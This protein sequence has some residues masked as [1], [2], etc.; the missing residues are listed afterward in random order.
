MKFSKLLVLSALSLFGLGAN[1]A[2]LIERTEPLEPDFG[3]GQLAVDN[4]EA[5]PVD[6]VVGDCYVIY[7]VGSQGYFSEGNAWGTQASISMETPLLA[8]FT[9]PDGKTLEDAALLFNDYPNT[10]NTWKLAFFDTAT[11]MYVDRGSQPNIYWQVVAGNGDKTYRLQASA[12]NPNYNPSAYPG[13]VG[14][15]VTEDEFNTALHPFLLEGEGHYIDWQFFAVP[16]WT[17]YF[18]EK[19]LYDVAMKLKDQIEAA[20]AMGINVSAA[21]AVFNNLN[22][23]I[24]ELQAAI[25][26]LKEAMAGGISSGTPD[27]PSDATVLISNPN[28]DNA[29]SD[30]WSGTAPNM[31]GSGSHG[32][33]NVAE[34][35]NNTFDTYQDLGE[36]PAGVFALRAKT[37]FRGSWTDHLNGTPAAAKLYANVGDE[38]NEVPFNNIWSC[39]NTEPMAGSTEFG[40][41]AAENTTSANG[42]SYYSPNDPSAF[43]LYEEKGFYDTTLFFEVTE[44]QKVRIGVKNPSKC[45]DGCDNWSIFDTFTLLYYGNETG[46][47]QKWVE[48]SVPTVNIAEGTLF[49]QAYYDAYEQALSGVTA[50]NKAE[51]EAAIEAVKAVIADLQKNISLWQSYLKKADTATAMTIDPKYEFLISTGDLADYLMEDYEDIVNEVALTNEELEAEI[52]KLDALMQ[53]VLKEFSDQIP[54]DTD[55]TDFLTNPDFEF[56][57]ASGAAEGWTVTVTNNSQGGNIT[58]GPLGNENDQLMIDAMGKTNHCF[59]SWHVW[60]FDVWQEVKEVPAGVY[61]I[62]VQGYVRCEASGYTQ[63]DEV[64]PTTIPIKLYMN[65][66][67]SNFPSVYSEDITEDHYI[68]GSLPE[69]ETWSWTGAVPN[70]PNSMGAASLCFAWDMY[71]VET[72]GLVKPGESMRIGVKG[73]MQSNWWCIWDNFH[74]TYQGMLPEYVQP[75]LEAAL[76]MVDLSKPMGKSIFAKVDALNAEAQEAIATGDGKTMFS[77]LIK[78][79]DLTDE[80][81]ESVALFAQLSAATES[82]LEAA[83]LSNNSAA[84]A[85]A[86]VL[87]DEIENGINNHLFENEDVEPYLA[88]IAEMKTKLLWPAS[89]NNATDDAPADVTIVVANP[90]YDENGDGWLG[91]PASRNADATNS[92]I[93]NSE[94][95][96]YYQ[97]IVGLPEGT[98]QVSVQGYYRAGYAGNDYATKDSIQYSHAFLYAMNGAQEMSAVPLTRLASEPNQGPA[99]PDGYAWASEEEGLYVPNSMTTGGYEFAADKFLNNKVIVKVGADGKLRF[100]LKKDQKIEGDWTL[101]DNWTL[102]YFGQNSSKPADGDATGIENIEGAQSFTVEYFTLDGRKATS[103]Q[104]GIMIQ[105]VTLDNG[106][107]II[108]KIRK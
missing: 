11:Q 103:A 71:K 14:L 77:V 88:K 85:E 79:E 93:Y 64:D 45:T 74:I 100:G 19:D 91:T 60:G 9:L 62:T 50:S 13:F 55:C 4:F 107:T 61:Q 49:T 32:P 38:V 33:A 39:L 6:F 28:F 20:E 44:G 53:A 43:R 30:G 98:Y 26:A 72:F 27:N 82:L 102:T 94:G 99:L 78:V 58:P 104:K 106:A 8:R 95:Y 12:Y 73:D 89:A 66:S 51:A 41:S 17:N 92:E 18:K 16:E 68:D 48:Q 52:E 75:A 42:T 5:T 36:L 63:G 31:V 7:N 3:P 22:S 29:S 21:E 23:T 67:Q 101:W 81:N 83:S 46:S 97:E 96:D 15:D 37:A 59:E 24:A 108:K 76:A 90:S 70:Y 34:V 2:N 57:L 69:I 54:P 105:K 86:N 1:A 47:Y 40:T 84:R 25:D 80:I 65:K 10:K 56:G 87:I 35:Y